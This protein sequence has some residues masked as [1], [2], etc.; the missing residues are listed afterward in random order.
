MILPLQF[1]QR[2]DVVL[3]SKELLGKN[4]FTDFEGSLTGGIIVETEAYRA[5]DDKACHAFGNK[6]TNRTKTMFLEG[7]TMYVYLSYGIHTMINVV[8]ASKGMAHA[9]LIR[10]IEPTIGVSTMLQ[11]RN[12]TQL[13]YET[14][15]GP[16][17]TACALGVEKRHDG[18]LLNSKK[19]KVWIEDSG[20]QIEEEDIVIGPR[21]GMSIHTGPD[22]HRQWRFYINSNK[23]VSKPKIAKYPNIPHKS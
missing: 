14:V 20:I 23:W 13:A 8:T 5:P 18:L 1:Y 4:I 9:I 22:A 15:N 10:A 2:D 19:S 16:G 17:K 11:R 21:V 7:G 12:H 6:M 3:I